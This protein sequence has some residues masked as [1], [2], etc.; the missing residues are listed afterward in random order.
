MGEPMTAM[1]FGSYGREE[2]TLLVAS[3][4]GA[5]RQKDSNNSVPQQLHPWSFLE[6]RQY[7]Q[8]MESKLSSHPASQTR[9]ALRKEPTGE[10]LRKH[11]PAA[12]P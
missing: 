6:R 9:N 3:H 8:P 7:D 10:V 4:A 11:N 12:T 5:E 1:R 2:G